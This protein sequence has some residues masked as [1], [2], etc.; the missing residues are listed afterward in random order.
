MAEAPKAKMQYGMCSLRGLV[1]VRAEEIV[2][3]RLG[4][5]GLKVSKII[6]GC[7]TYGLKTWA[8]WVLDEEEGIKHIKY[9]YAPATLFSH[10]SDIHPL[11]PVPGMT[12]VSKPSTPQ[13][14]VVYSSTLSSSCITIPTPLGLLQRRV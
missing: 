5:S 3:V 6:L 2:A 7:M 12:P 11:R 10:S 14:S 13:T 9:A 1:L 4:N 8:D